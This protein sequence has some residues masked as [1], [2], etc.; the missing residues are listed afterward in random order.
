MLVTQ[1]TNIE[2]TMTK[3]NTA[4]V[5]PV[6][7]RRA[8]KASRSSAHVFP[9]IFAYSF[10][11]GWPSLPHKWIHGFP[12][13]KGELVCLWYVECWVKWAPCKLLPQ[14]KRTGSGW[15]GV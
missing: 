13:L 4:I 3:E 9:I 14:G 12:V 2:L 5:T 1:I 7:R 11:T 10:Q 8:V 15:N 6:N